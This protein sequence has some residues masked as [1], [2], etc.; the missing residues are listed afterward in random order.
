MSRT[1]VWERAETQQASQAV[2]RTPHWLREQQHR[3]LMQGRVLNGDDRLQQRTTF[4]RRRV[5]SSSALCS[6]ARSVFTCSRI[7][8]HCRDGG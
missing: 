6:F 8:L 7:E 4:S 5:T 2:L 1:H 3:R